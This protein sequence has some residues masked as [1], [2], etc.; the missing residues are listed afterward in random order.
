MGRGK[1]RCW[2]WFSYLPEDGKAA[3]VELDRLT[4]E[5]WTL[6]RLLGPLACF[7]RTEGKALQCW[8]ELAHP[9]KKEEQ[10]EF[11]ELCSQAGWEILR[12][13]GGLW[14]FRAKEGHAPAPIQTDHWLEWEAVWRKTLLRQS[15]DLL[16]V[17]AVWLFYLA[18]SLTIRPTRLY[19][20]QLFFNN[21]SMAICG[22]LLA[23]LMGKIVHGGWLLLYRCRC[24]RS[25]ERMGELPVPNRHWA[26]LRGLAPVWNG[27]LWGILVACLFLGRGPERYFD[28][29]HTS[30]TVEGSW[31]AQRQEYLS[32][33]GEV[34][35]LVERYDCS[36]H[37]WLA[38]LVENGLVER[39]G[40]RTIAY[41][42]LH[43]P[44]TLRP[45]DLEEF[46]SAWLGME[47]GLE[48]LVARQGDQIVCI[49]APSGLADSELRREIWDN[50]YGGEENA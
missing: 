33:E 1:N 50:A 37:P 3:Q 4:E 8:V 46:E 5:G 12:Q 10:K 16:G 42:H 18:I 47:D 39:E 14:Y 43:D 44:I 20:W 34:R 6:V 15:L 26:G 32:Y 17:V 48:C 35:T 25:M 22:L 27:L 28:G 36:G 13:R 9:G 24:R 31:L 7:Q 49:E 40:E 30:R 11:L 23:L 45:V 2:R 29:V 21:W 41:V 38:R 19:W